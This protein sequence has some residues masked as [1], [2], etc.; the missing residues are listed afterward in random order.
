M[1]FLYAALSMAFRDACGT[2]LVVA[3]ARNRPVI[4]GL[5]DATGDLATVLVTLFGAGE[6]LTHGWNLRT[7]ALLATIAIVS[8]GG[9]MGWTHL[10]S[11]IRIKP[12]EGM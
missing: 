9:T 4:A 10:A 6:V 12:T 11:R 1:V 7:G 2:L 8:F 5:A 3:E